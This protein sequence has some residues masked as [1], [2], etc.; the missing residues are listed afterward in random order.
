MEKN[1]L[2]PVCNSLQLLAC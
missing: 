1:P 2:A